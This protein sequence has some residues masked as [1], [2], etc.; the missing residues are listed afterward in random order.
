[1]LRA[2]D[3]RTLFSP[4][5]FL[6]PSLHFLIPFLSSFPSLILLFFL[7]SLHIESGNTTKIECG[8]GFSCSTSTRSELQM[9]TATTLK[10]RRYTLDNFFPPDPITGLIDLSQTES[11]SSSSSQSQHQDGEDEDEVTDQSV[12]ESLTSNAKSTTTS[13]YQSTAEEVTETPAV[14]QKAEDGCL[15]PIIPRQDKD[16]KTEQGVRFGS[17]TD[18]RHEFFISSSLKSSLTDESIFQ[19]EFKTDSGGQ[20]SSASGVL[21]YVSGSNDI[22]FVSIFM[23]DGY[24]YYLWN[25]GGGTAMIQSKKTFNDDQW[26][27][28]TFKRKSRKGFLFIDAEEIGSEESPNDA[29]SQLNVKNPIYVGGVPETST[30][31][32]RTN[33]RGVTVSF[34]GCLRG[35]FVNGIQLGFFVDSVPFNA[36]ACSD[37]VEPGFFFHSTDDHFDVSKETKSLMETSFVILKDKFRVGIDMTIKLSIKPRTKNGIV[38]SVRGSKDFLLLQML[39]GKVKLSVDNGAG[40][41]S[42]VSGVPAGGLCD[43][44]WHTILAIKRENVVELGI[45]GGDRFEESGIGDVYITDTNSPLF[46][47]GLP[48]EEMS[49][50]SGLDTKEHFVGCIKDIVINEVSMSVSNTT[51]KGHVTM[52]TCPTI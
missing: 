8:N 25:C 38:L 42:V 3:F 52:N 17:R 23:S 11:T 30:R 16:V 31:Q 36:P 39:D 14:K 29:S 19:I 20:S 18:S 50:Y 51:I 43:G 13:I 7:P 46:V 48:E 4:F 35:L 34:P 10:V 22:D 12:I 37:L 1:M 5:S 33:L 47:G 27:H 9:K 49:G 41:I 45:D 44:S 21:F 15:L 24:I 26:H 2:I 32:S 40:I 6:F 28:I